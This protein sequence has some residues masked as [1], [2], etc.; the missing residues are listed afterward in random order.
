M[1]LGPQATNLSGNVSGQ[2][3]LFYSQGTDWEQWFHRQARPGTPGVAG[4]ACSRPVSSTGWTSTPPGGSEGGLA[5]L[6]QGT[7]GLGI[8]IRRGDVLL[9]S[10]GALCSRSKARAW[11]ARPT[12]GRRLAAQRRCVCWGFRRKR[13]GV[14]K[15]TCLLGDADR[16]RV[17]VSAGPEVHDQGARGSGLFRLADGRLPPRPRTAAAGASCASRTARGTSH[18]PSHARTGGIAGRG[19]HGCHTGDSVNLAEP[20]F[21]QQQ[22]YSPACLLHERAGTCLFQEAARERVRPA[23]LLL[24]GVGRARAGAAPPGPQLVTEPHFE[25][26]PLR[27]MFLEPPRALVTQTR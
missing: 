14:V 24:L 19:P 1:E 27:I 7:K 6:S 2:C 16:G 26:H 8:G 18:V 23:A 5:A 15:V 20:H 25:D 12:P 22:P 10:Q 13:R 9:P 3:L 21:Q 11:G 17:H 4:S